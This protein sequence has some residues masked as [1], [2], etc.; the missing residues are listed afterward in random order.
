MTPKLQNASMYQTRKENRGKHNRDNAKDEQLM[1]MH[2]DHNEFSCIK[3]NIAG[4]R[5][6]KVKLRR[7]SS[8][9]C[10]GLGV[11]V[12]QC[13]N[14]GF[15]FGMTSKE[16]PRVPK[17]TP[18]EWTLGKRL[19]RPPPRYS[20][21]IP[22]WEPFQIGSLSALRGIPDGSHSERQYFFEHHA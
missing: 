2:I 10:S 5:F 6:R 20:G 8:G 16:N 11:F 15:Q 18:T 19:R 3:S 1:V 13:P 17:F 9:G 14:S 4:Y 7:L 12:T 21:A 22:N